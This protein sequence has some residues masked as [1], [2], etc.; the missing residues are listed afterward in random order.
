MVSDSTPLLSLPQLL[1]TRKFYF[2]LSQDTITGYV[3]YSDLNR[4]VAK[5][6][7]FALFQDIEARLWDHINSV[8]QSN[9]LE[10][11]LNRDRAKNLLKKRRSRERAGTDI[12]WTGLFFF[13]DILT[14]AKHHGLIVLTEIEHRTLVTKRNAVVHPDRPLVAHHRAVKQLLDVR[15]LCERLVSVLPSNG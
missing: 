13:G 15:D 2:V 5:L 7:F 9:D 1:S 10:A 14:L 6:P 3:H 8:T 4:T 12:G 11:A